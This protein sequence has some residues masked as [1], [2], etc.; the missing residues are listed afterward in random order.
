MTMTDDWYEKLRCPRCGK[1][2]MATLS[3]AKGQ[4][5]TVEVIPDGFKAVR[6]ANGPN[7]HCTTCKVAAYP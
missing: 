6:T 5:P 7:F 2:G 3:E 1:T 4:T